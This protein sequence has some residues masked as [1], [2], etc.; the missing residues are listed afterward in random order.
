MNP[1]VVADGCGCVELPFVNLAV[2]CGEWPPDIWLYSGCMVGLC[3]PLPLFRCT[4]CRFDVTL[5]MPNIAG[6]DAAGIDTGGPGL[7][8]DAG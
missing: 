4:C 8:I 5:S 7:A 3:T 1:G 6:V 2:V